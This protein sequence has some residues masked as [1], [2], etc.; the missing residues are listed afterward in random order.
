MTRWR[1]LQ[2]LDGTLLQ[3]AGRD[4]LSRVFQVD[5]NDGD[6]TSTLERL[7]LTQQEFWQVWH[8]HQDEI[9]ERAVPLK[10]A[11]ETVRSLKAEGAR[12]CIVTARRIEAEAVT[13]RWLAT[14]EVPYDEF[15]MNADDKAAV[16]QEL[17]L[18]LGFEDDPKHALALAPVMPVV[19]I[20]NSKNHGLSIDS[21]AIHPVAGWHQVRPLLLQLAA[22]S[23]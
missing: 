9:Y 18:N 2:D 15:V 19:L 16:A 13:R 20:Q 17:Q 8:Q 6:A 5:L 4:V 14:H 3:N 23:A 1:I 12:I 22:Q 10:G 11:I 21:P 7:G